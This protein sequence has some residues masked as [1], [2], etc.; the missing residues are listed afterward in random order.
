[1]RNSDLIAF[2]KPILNQFSAA[3]S[4]EFIDVTGQVTDIQ[5]NPHRLTIRLNVPA[6]LYSGR[7]ETAPNSFDMST[8]MI[9]MVRV[10]DGKRVPVGPWDLDH[11]RNVMAV[12]MMRTFVNGKLKGGLWFSMPGPAQIAGGQLAAEFGF[13]AQEGENELILELIERDRERMNWGR[14]AYFELRK[15][16]RRTI[17]LEPASA[18]RPRV[19]L[20][21]DDVKRVHAR[22]Q[23]STELEALQQ[24]LR[25]EDLVFLTDNSQGTLEVASLVF[26]LTGDE[27]IGARVK[28][29]IMELAHAPTWSGRPEPLL[30]GGENDRVIGQK[31]YHT[32]LAWDYLR[33]LFNDEDRRAILSKAEDY[34]QKIY[35][36]TLLQRA[37]MGYPTIDPHSLGAWNGAAIACMAFYED[38]AIARHALP[39]FHGLFC[40]SLKLF[41]ASG[42]A[43]WA[44]Y[45]PFHLV[46]Y[47]AAAHT[48]GGKRPELSSSPFLDNLG[49]RIIGCLRSTQQ[50]GTAA[51]FTDAGASLSHGISLPLPSH[52]RH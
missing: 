29:R 6:G 21:S 36:F 43:A 34:L 26:A 22:W 12:P 3:D 5:A 23:G 38:L 24:R 19:F 13:E 11:I 41:P 37:Y 32:A 14:L 20:S 18:R 46:L 15:D 50:P 49:Q 33:P 25:T 27:L 4:V 2:L 40:D 39:L 51:R 17:P 28:A 8:A 44:T 52:A 10:P 7:F 31:L 47:L 16:D 30:M 42:K 35:D 45:F 1:M 9:D 48:F